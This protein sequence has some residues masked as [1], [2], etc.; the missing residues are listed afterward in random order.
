MTGFPIER[1]LCKLRIGF[2]LKRRNSR[3]DWSVQKADLV[4]TQAINS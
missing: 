2:G 3:R 1:T 4:F